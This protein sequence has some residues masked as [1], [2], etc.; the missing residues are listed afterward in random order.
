MRNSTRRRTAA[1]F[2]ALSLV[3][4]GG[5][6]GSEPIPGGTCNRAGARTTGPGDALNYFPAEVGRSWTY[7]QESTGLTGTV[8][9]TGTQVVAGETAA[10]FT[11]GTTGSTITENELIVKRPGGVYLLSSQSSEPFGLDQ[12]YPSLLLPF[13]VAPMP[14][15]EQANCR[16]LDVGDLDGDGKADHA[17]VVVSLQVFAMGETASLA[18]GFF[19]DL[20]HAQTVAQVTV[21]GTGGQKVTVAVT[22]DDW[23]ARDVGRI[24]SLMKLTNI[25]AAF[26]QSSTTSLLSWSLPGA[27]AVPSS[28][29][30]LAVAAS[31]APAATPLE[32]ATLRLA[33]RAAGVAR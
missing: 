5:G 22:Q 32:E 27:Q 11:S 15:T 1:A 17:D 28:A 6:G 29:Q 19:S 4:C 9:V 13:P 14:L 10:V 2:F 24:L 20:A 12:I 8:S 25:A 30:A 18:T 23:F 26:S 31:A 3:A 21:T 33:R 16:A 7:R